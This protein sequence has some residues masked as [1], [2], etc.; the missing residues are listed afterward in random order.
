MAFNLSPMAF[1][2]GLEPPTERLEDVLL[3]YSKKFK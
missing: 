3:T 2:E 1:Q